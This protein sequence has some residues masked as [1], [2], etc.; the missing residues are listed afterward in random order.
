MLDST[1][2][3]LMLPTDYSNSDFTHMFVFI[4]VFSLCLKSM[5]SAKTQLEGVLLKSQVKRDTD[6]PGK[7][8][9]RKVAECRG[10]LAVP[11]S[12]T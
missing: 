4:S 1:K 11:K 5:I 9:T 12:A 7:G 2:H 6:K 3:V 10:L 8:S